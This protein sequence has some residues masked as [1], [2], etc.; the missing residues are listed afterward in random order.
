M[1]PN[2]CRPYSIRAVFSSTPTLH[3]ALPRTGWFLMR[4]VDDKKLHFTAF[5]VNDEK[6]VK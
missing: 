3:N 4:K 5:S 2:D 1:I 6:N